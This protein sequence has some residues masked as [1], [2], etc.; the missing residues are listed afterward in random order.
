MTHTFPD[1]AA[2]EKH[3][4]EHGTMDEMTI[5]GHDFIMDYYDQS[6]REIYYRYADGQDVAITV[7]TEDRYGWRK[8][9]DAVCTWV[10]G[11]EIKD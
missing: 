11:P 1:L 4:R 3:V 6:G 8:F 5:G 10:M 7:E 9:T 2:F